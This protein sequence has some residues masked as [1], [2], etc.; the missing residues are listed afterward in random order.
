MRAGKADPRR[1]DEGSAPQSTG[2]RAEFLPPAQRDLRRKDQHLH[3]QLRC[4][5]RT[6][7]LP[8]G[9]GDS[10]EQRRRGSKS[11]PLGHASRRLLLQR[12]L[13]LRVTGSLHAYA[14]LPQRVFLILILLCM[15]KNISHIV[16]IQT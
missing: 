4:E 6:A 7:P 5:P 1:A 15:D 11:E 8:L 3:V 16:T 2:L 12:H 14:Q 10:T 13:L 9:Q